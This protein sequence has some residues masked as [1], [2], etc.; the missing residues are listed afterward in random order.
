MGGCPQFTASTAVTT[1]I[2]IKQQRSREGTAVKLRCERDVL[3]E[4]LSTAGRAVA[5]RS[6]ALP[7]LGG[8]RLSVTGDVLQVT[9]TDLDLTITVETTVSGGSDGIVVAPG[10]LVTDIVRALE[11]GAVVLEADEDG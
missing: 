7:V 3:A 2:S 4:A 8:V 6:G 9:G 11:P 10:R 5:G 1:R